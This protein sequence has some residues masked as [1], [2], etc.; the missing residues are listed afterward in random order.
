MLG[1]CRGLE[2]F[3]RPDNVHFQEQIDAGSDAASLDGGS[4]VELESLGAG[5]KQE[6]HYGRLGKQ[7]IEEWNSE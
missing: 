6:Y 2:Y 7:R 5:I 1:N 4:Q 3:R